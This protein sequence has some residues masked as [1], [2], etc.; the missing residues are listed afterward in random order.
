[1]IIRTRFDSVAEKSCRKYCVLDT[2]RGFV[3]SC[4]GF[5]EE[6]WSEMFE[7]NVVNFNRFSC[8]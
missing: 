1:M 3:L 6:G 5:F 8:D 7:A 4:S 2:G